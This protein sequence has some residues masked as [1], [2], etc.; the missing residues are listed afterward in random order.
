MK[1]RHIVLAITGASGAIYGLKLGRELLRAGVRVTMLITSA[2]FLVLKEECGHDWQGSEE[3]VADHLFEYFQA[4]D[5][6]V[7]F[8]AE[9]NLFAPIASGS[10]APDAMV[11]C[12]CSMGTVSRIACGNSANL[13]ERCADV[14]LKERRKLVM[15]PRETP[16]NEIHLENMLKLSRMGVRMVPAMP[17]F[18]HSPASVDDLVSFMVGKV[19]DQLGIPHQLFRRWGEEAGIGE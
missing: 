2:G 15:V 8:Y 13:L 12:P 4:S 1:N 16:L 3:T 17:A 7:V 11:I 18:Y 10:S 5:R 19:L 14:M 9:E 6:N